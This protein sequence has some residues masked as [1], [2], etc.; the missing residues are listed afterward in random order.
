M[1]RLLLA[2]LILALG[3]SGCAGASGN[4]VDASCSGLEA[5]PDPDGLITKFEAERIATK[6]LSSPWPEVSG[7]EIERVWAICLTTLRS[8]EQD[9]RSQTIPGIQPTD[10][11]VWVV[12]V[13]GISRPEG[14]SA[15]NASDPYHFALI[16]LSAE[17]SGSIS[18]SRHREP[19]MVP[20]GDIE[21]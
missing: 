6:L 13:K 21:Q 12:E 3:A 15:S 18:G 16:V 17:S 14:I 4:A 10:P 5:I 1:K 8:Y 19:V 9:L 7:T 20:S 2:S 11:P